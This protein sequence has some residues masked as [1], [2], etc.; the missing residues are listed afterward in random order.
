MSTLASQLAAPW[1][2]LTSPVIS[3]SHLLMAVSAKMEPT[4]MTVECAYFSQLV[5]AI[6]REPQ[7]HL[8]RWFMTLELSGKHFI[9]CLWIF[10]FIF[11]SVNIL[12]ILWCWEWRHFLANYLRCLFFKIK[13]VLSLILIKSNNLSKILTPA[14]HLNAQLEYWNV[15]YFFLTKHA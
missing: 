15:L 6:T 12:D 7:C 5:L 10:L 14:K 2:I 8:E 11:S 4:W 9:H 3:R 1:V 13:W